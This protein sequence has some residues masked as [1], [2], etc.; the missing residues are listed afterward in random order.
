MIPGNKGREFLARI[1][2]AAQD[3]LVSVIVYG[4]AAAGDFHQEYSDINLFCVL[5]DSSFAKL[6]ALAPTVKWWDRQKQ[7]PPL[8]MTRDELERTADVF[9][10]ELMDMKQH[11][12]V[13]FGEDVLQELKIPSKLHRVQVE[14]ELGEKLSL[15]RR[16][17]LLASGNEK[18]MWELLTQSVS[19]FT[20][21]FRHALIVLGHEAPQGKRDA[22][23][24]LAS[25]IG[26]DASGFLQVL[27]VRERRVK[28]GKLDVTDVFSRYLAAVDQVN[29]TVDRMLD[30][31]EKA[32][33]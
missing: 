8:F 26:F 5:R 11:R 13:I 30:S 29:A 28:R 2:E 9:S 17:L 23:Q 14:Y 12:R 20:T 7:P 21:L 31:G 18:K 19:S 27:D 33:S 3:N 15:L 6:Q 4:S 16:H 24:A 1:R 22:V 10:I 25:K 32:S